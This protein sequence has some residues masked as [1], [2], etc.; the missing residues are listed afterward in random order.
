MKVLIVDDSGVMRRVLGRELVAVG[1]VT[2]NLSEA[3]D[4]EEALTMVAESTYDLI[5]MDWNMPNLLGID[6]VREIRARGITTPILM[7]TTEAEK[8]NVVTAIQAGANNYLIKPFTKDDLQE[9]VK[10]LLGPRLA[11]LSASAPVPDLGQ[12]VVDV[13]SGRISSQ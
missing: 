10:Q 1:F 6:A 11:E 9:K 8:S 13:A 12:Q 5:T 2:E 3:A 4:G 7:V